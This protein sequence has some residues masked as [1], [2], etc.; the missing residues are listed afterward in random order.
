MESLGVV[1][2]AAGL[3]K[4]MR[5]SRA[6]VLHH[7]GG[8]PL[9]Q[10][11]L[12]TVQTLCPERLVV[13][14]GHQAEEIKRV[15]AS[16]DVLFAHQKEQRGTGDAVRAAEESFAGFAGDVLILCGDAPLLTPATLSR[17]V[18]C[19]RDAGAALS[20][21]TVHIEDPT[22]YGRIIRGKNGRIQR[23]VEE[24]DASVQEKQVQEVNTGIFCVR[25][26]FLFPA[27]KRV[28]TNNA[29]GDY[30][31]TDIVAM[32]VE[33][34]CPVQT[35]PVTVIDPLEVV[36]VNSREELARME[37]ALQ[38][39]I[40]S[41]W[42]TAGVTLEDPDTVYIDEDVVISRDTVIGPNTHLK[43]QTIIGEGCR[44]D[45]SAYVTNCRLGNGVHV[46]FSVVLSDSELGEGVEV[47]PFAHLRGGAKLAPQSEIGNFVE[48]KKST[49]GEKTK[50]KHLSLIHI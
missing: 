1:V 33:D 40:R 21:L 8:K 7:L 44:I 34:D 6:K 2:L 38:E 27:L 35:V 49:I 43:G 36:G 18:D 32:A 9:V 45:G 50:A 30:Y 20:L 15:C 47:G 13:V 16:D 25:Y 14:V 31:L 26:D 29:R 3:G 39:K 37:R 12:H 48:V 42:M 4:R 46:K 24:Q 28:Q 11:V 17:L 19:H 5:S 10:H 22:G 23:I 41:R